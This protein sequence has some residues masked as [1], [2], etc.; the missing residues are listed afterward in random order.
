M[1]L[2]ASIMRLLRH[3]DQNTYNKNQYYRVN[4]F[5]FNYCSCALASSL[6]FLQ[7]LI[8]TSK[9][10]RTSYC[11]EIDLMDMFLLTTKVKKR[12]YHFFSIKDFGHIR[13]LS[14][15][16]LCLTTGQEYPA[17]V[18][19]APFQK[20]AKKKTKR[21]DAKCGTIVEGNLWHEIFY[22]CYNNTSTLFDKY[23]T[24]HLVFKFDI[25]VAQSKVTVRLFCFFSIC[26]CLDP[27]YKRF[28]EIY[29]GDEEKLAST[30]ETLLEELEARSKE[31]VGW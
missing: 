19:F 26:V 24:L 23:L 1:I 12:K 9:T 22:I 28:L 21:K 20:T 18:E 31:L 2:G 10:K 29:N 30:P 5:F 8:S 15:F 13:T 3:G 7:G 11:S 14:P 16:Q 17:V 6:T 27:E 25:D 4:I